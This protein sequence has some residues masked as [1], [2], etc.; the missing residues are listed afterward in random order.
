MTRPEAYPASAITSRKPLVIVP[1]D[2]IGSKG[3][4]TLDRDDFEWMISEGFHDFDLASDGTCT[5][6]V[7]T[8]GG[9]RKREVAK[10][11][12]ERG[13]V[14]YRDRDSTNLRRTNLTMVLV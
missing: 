13:R 2:P 9:V 7:P 11:L 4:V 12:L 1:L 5:A 8:K 14:K 10:A 3:S 6:L